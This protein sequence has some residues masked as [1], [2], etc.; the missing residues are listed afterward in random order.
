MYCTHHDLLEPLV[1]VVQPL[2][3]Q[4][5]TLL[6][7]AALAPFGGGDDNIDRYIELTTSLYRFFSELFGSLS[8]LRVSSSAVAVSVVFF[9]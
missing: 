5:K 3:L 7:R 6:P 2:E 1:V 8:N 9:S 4:S